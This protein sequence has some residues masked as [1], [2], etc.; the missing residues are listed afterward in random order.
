M[1]DVEGRSN[2]VLLWREQLRQKTQEASSQVLVEQV[3]QLLRANPLEDIASAICEQIYNQL[4]ASSVALLRYASARLQ[5]VAG[6]Q[7]RYPDGTRLPCQ[8]WISS[9][10]RYPVQ[11]LSRQGIE[12]TWLARQSEADYEWIIPLVSRSQVMGL[13]VITGNEAMSVPSWQAPL[14]TLSVLLACAWAEP[15][16]SGRAR[17]NER[18]RHEL[19]LLTPREKEVMALLPQG[20]ANARIAAALGISLGTVKTHIEHILSKLQLDDRAHAAARA[21]E[22]KLGSSG[23]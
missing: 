6:V 17:L 4:N 2:S 22:L 3:S 8:G 1:T 12:A 23:L 11:P 16:S 14:S 21:V 19:N 13:L 18:Q 7:L 20:M 15:A 10:L 5:L 9:L